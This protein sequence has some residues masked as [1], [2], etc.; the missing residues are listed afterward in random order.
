MKN[1]KFVLHL[2]V[3]VVKAL[4]GSVVVGMLALFVGER[5]DHVFVVLLD[6]QGEVVSMVVHVYRRTL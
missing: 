3:N 5:R 1:V 2:F 6:L 4:L